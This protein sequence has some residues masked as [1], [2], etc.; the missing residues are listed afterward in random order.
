[1]RSS[2]LSHTP[3]DDPGLEAAIRAAGGTMKLARAL[4]ITHNAISVW[5]QVPVKRVRDVARLT[6][7]PKHVLRPDIYDPPG[8]CAA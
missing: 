4:G 1:M 6:G 2:K 8:E 5:V 3:K 7:I